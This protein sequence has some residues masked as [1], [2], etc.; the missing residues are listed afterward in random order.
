MNTVTVEGQLNEARS[1]ILTE[2][3]GSAYT[4]NSV[5]IANQAQGNNASFN[6]VLLRAPGVAEDSLGQ[7]HVRGEYANLQYRINDVL[8]PEGASERFRDIGA[9]VPKGVLLVGPPGT[10]KT[11]LARAVAGEAGVPFLSV[12]GSDF[13]EMFVGVGASRVRDLFQTARK[14]APAIIFVDEI[15][16]I[17]RKR[18]AGLGGGHDEREQTLNQ[19]LPQKA[20]SSWRRRTGPTSSTPHCCARVDS[21]ARSSCPYQISTSASRS[22]RFTVATSGSDPTLTSRSSRAGRPA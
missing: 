15:D 13:M 1:S 21:T 17:G 6:Q 11:L 3:G 16:S 9:R 22:C 5:A 10:G 19:M 7:V 2:I 20:S 4:I 8:L 12:S 18:G 14:Q